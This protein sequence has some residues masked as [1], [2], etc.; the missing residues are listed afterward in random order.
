MEHFEIINHFMSSSMDF[1]AASL[2]KLIYD[3]TRNYE[4]QTEVIL[5][6]IAKPFDTVPHNRLRLKL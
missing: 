5:M 2:V 6:D 1:E 3:L 4:K